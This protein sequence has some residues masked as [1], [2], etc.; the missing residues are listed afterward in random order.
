MRRSQAGCFS[1]RAVVRVFMGRVNSAGQKSCFGMVKV[2]VLQQ[3][4]K[5]VKKNKNLLPRNTLSRLSQWIDRV[6][7][8]S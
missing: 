4:F 7:R 1:H 8:V 6:H 3:G 5:M 2:L